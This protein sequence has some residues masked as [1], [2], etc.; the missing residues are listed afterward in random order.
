M[1]RT[2]FAA[3]AVAL[4][5]ASPAL[6][7][8][9][10]DGTRRSD[11]RSWSGATVNV[12]GD[13]IHGGGK[14]KIRQDI[15]ASGIA[16][17]LT[18]AGVHSCAGSASLGMA[19]TGFN[20]GIGSTYEMQECN[21]RAY[22]ATLADLGMSGAAL[23]LI[24]NNPEVQGALNQTGVV[25][26]QQK[27]AMAAAQQ[28]AAQQQAAHTQQQAV[29]AQQ[30]RTAYVSQSQPRNARQARQVAAPAGRN[31]CHGSSAQDM[32]ECGRIMTR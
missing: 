12:S 4:L 30:Q 29:F 8:T 2:F 15:T 19:A 1:K 17:G 5:A 3:A 28:A 23:A 18:A 16:P 9:V 10:T 11:S 20:F 27:A 14:T 7:Q 13:T 25:C 32:L 31:P 22:A 24:C 21:R 6:A 26:P